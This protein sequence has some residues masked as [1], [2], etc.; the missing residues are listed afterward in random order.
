MF[1][2]DTH[3]GCRA[4]LVP[5]CRMT[6]ASP[7]SHVHFPWLEEIALN[8]L[9]FHHTALTW[10]W[11]HVHRFE[12]PQ[13]WDAVPLRKSILVR[14]DSHLWLKLLPTQPA[15]MPSVLPAEEVF[16]AGEAFSYPVS[17]LGCYCPPETSI[18]RD[19][20]ADDS[21]DGRIQLRSRQ[22]RPRCN[23][24]L[25]WGIKS[26][27]CSHVCPLLLTLARIS[28]SYDNTDVIKTGYNL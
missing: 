26:R 19:D 4:Q 20:S 11:K 14:W 13:S 28:R 25:F 27:L 16:K 24:H 21:G 2:T 18:D 8:R 5:H 10:Y 12:T 22:Y 9:G 23:K 7:L 6:S 3:L 1:A 17:A 15:I